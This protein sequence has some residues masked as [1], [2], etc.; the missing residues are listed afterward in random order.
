MCKIAII[1]NYALFSSGITKILN[2]IETFNVVSEAE[3]VE[4]M[5]L[6]LGEIIPDVIVFDIIHHSDAGIKS[7]KRIRRLF[8]KTSLLLIVSEDYGLYFEEYIHLGVR[9]LALSNVS[10]AQ[11]IKAIH[12]LENDEDYFTLDV[13]NILK[14]N[15]RSG[16]SGFLS[17]KLKP[18]LSD[19]ETDVAKLFCEG[20]S[21]KEIGNRLNISPRTV[22]THK[23]NILS[24][25]NLNSLA[26]IIKYTMLNSI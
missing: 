1:E 12:K 21:Y 17:P 14:E 10:S 18:K 2:E 20:L 16:K 24:K 13:W 23:N 5:Q 7:L 9:G 3:N 6:H 19:R 22:E 25:L 15:L 8:P 4:Q 11:L 26:D